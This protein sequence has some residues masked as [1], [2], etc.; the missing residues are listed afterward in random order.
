MGKK[1]I[2]SVSPYLIVSVISLIIGL[3]MFRAREIYPMGEKSVL[4]MDLW[5]QYFSMYVNNKQADSIADMMYS[6]N[7]GFGFN[8]WAQSAYYCNSIFLLLFKILPVEALV[9]ALCVF[10]LLKFA[11]SASAFLAY[12]RYKVKDGSLVFSMVS[13][14]A[15]SVCAYML[16]YLSQ[17]MWTDVVIYTPLVMLGLEKIINER[18]PLMYTLI[19]AVTLISNFYVGYA[20]CIFCVLYF[21]SQTAVKLTIEKNDKKIRIGNKKNVLSSIIKFTV[22]SLIAGALSAFVIIPVY[23]AISNT[24]ASES[25]F[26]EEFKWYHSL[27]TVL[28]DL[29]PEQP[30]HQGYVGANIFSG[31]VL[32]ISIP[33]YFVSKRFPLKERVADYIVAV[34]LIFSLNCNYLD[35][36]WHG[37]HFPNQLPARW[38]FLVS[39][40]LIMMSCKGLCALKDISIPRAIIGSVAGLAV[41]FLTANGAGGG[42]KIDISTTTLVIVIS[43]AVA[44][45]AISIL[46]YQKKKKAEESENAEPIEEAP[47]ENNGGKFRITRKSIALAVSVVMA[48]VI[49]FDSG[50]N[51]IDVS[52]FEGENGTLVSD[53]KSYT[54]ALVKSYN[55]G[56]QWKSG[57]DDFYRVE[58]NN[59]HTFNCSMTGDYHGIRYYSSTMNG[60][61]FRFLKF[62]GNRVYAD[63]VSTVYSLCSPVQNSL[64]GLKYFM[65]FDRYLNNVVPD[66]TMLE[67]S[68]EGN[69]FENPTALPIAYAVSGD[70]LSYEV[71]DQ[72][73]PFYNQNKLVNAMYGEEINPYRECPVELVTEN[74]ELMESDDWNTNFFTN[75]TGQPSV[76]HYTFTAEEDGA[77]FIEHNFR[78]GTIHVTGENID[79]SLGTAQAMEYLGKLAPGAVVNVEVT[80]EGIGLGCYGLNI[81]KLDNEAWQTA[82]NKLSAHSL[83]VTEFKTTSITGTINMDKPGVMFAS[84]SQDGGWSVYCDGEKVDTYSIMD[85]FVGAN[86]PKGTHTIELKYSVPGLTAGLVISLVALAVLIALTVIDREK[87][88]KTE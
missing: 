10:V 51:F 27:T 64:F 39:F 16:A 88:K 70:V 1:I 80:L 15:Y 2:K 45:I 63:K 81:Y 23:M 30:L 38:S 82:Y 12:M 9:K 75:S 44:V 22:S 69:F 32:F 37:F 49:V 60:N 57:D 52:Q 29:M 21:I 65:D 72:I 87:S 31:T 84:I 62:M 43:F 25:T 71:D 86:I 42:E 11:F 76:F 40:F 17:F 7:G 13:A 4:C 78:A 28:Q 5:G 34:L 33:V 19:L 47:A 79:K 66:M 58:A 74:V 8:N 48:C 41:F 14:V 55:Y 61:V 77:Y 46:S 56:N 50:S 24:I 26:P 67:A 83:D 73:R 36:I 68:D 54:N 18:K 3:M 85:T 53:E 6:W 20:V 59:G 35:Y